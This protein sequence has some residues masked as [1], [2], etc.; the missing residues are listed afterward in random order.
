M[1]TTWIKQTGKK[2]HTKRSTL[3]VQNLKRFEKTGRNIYVYIYIYIY[4]EVTRQI[5]RL[6]MERL[7]RLEAAGMFDGWVVWAVLARGEADEEVRRR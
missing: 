4:K 6:A 5:A 3:V 7:L 1:S 2:N